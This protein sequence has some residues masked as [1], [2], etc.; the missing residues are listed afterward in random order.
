MTHTRDLI[1]ALPLKNMDGTLLMMEIL[2]RSELLGFDMD[3]IEH[4]LQVAAYLHRVG[5]R[6]QRDKM[7]R[8]H[9]IE[10]PLRGVL[11]AL[12]Y[13]CENQDIIIAII[14]HDTVEDNPSEFA[15]D[16]A[17]GGDIDAEDYNN[18]EVAFE[19]LRTHF[20]DNVERLVRGMTNR[21]LDQQMS[22][23]EKRLIYQTDVMEKIKDVEV[24]FSKLM[25]FIDNASGLHYIASPD[26]KRQTEHQ[27]QKYYPLISVFQD[28]IIRPDMQTI[29]PK[30]SIDIM[31][32]QLA[33]TAKTLE[34]LLPKQD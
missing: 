6:A 18:R 23:V 33:T 5:I 25:D 24:A 29:V 8:T 12:R 14:F 26:N 10:H 11:R 7:P 19:Y 13:G 16:I 17:G 2:Q 22:K 31:F 27:S 32:V 28:R 30:A 4:A 34:P 1:R 9:Y 3:K 21:I 20:S 15:V